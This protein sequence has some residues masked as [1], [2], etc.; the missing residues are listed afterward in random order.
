MAH[1]AQKVRGGPRASSCHPRGAW[2]CA[3]ARLLLAGA[4]WR[5]GDPDCGSRLHVHP[6]STE[7][8]A[9]EKLQGDKGGVPVP[10]APHQGGLAGPCVWWL[11]APGMT[12][13]CGRW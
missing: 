10:G 4:L 13:A 12:S 6:R 1:L 2:G 7:P 11:V 3:I 9:Q 8:R 5:H